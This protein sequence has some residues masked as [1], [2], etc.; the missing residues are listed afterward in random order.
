MLSIWSHFKEE[1]D[2]VGLSMAYF[3]VNLLLFISL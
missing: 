1:L 3:V 2:T